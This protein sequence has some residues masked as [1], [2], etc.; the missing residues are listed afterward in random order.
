MTRPVALGV[1]VGGTKTRAALVDPSG[2]VVASDEAPTGGVPQADPGLR[3]SLAVARAVADQAASFGCRVEC[4]GVGVP[5]FVEPDGT[6]HSALVI[7]WEEQP[8]DL[9]AVLGPTI[10]ES[11]VRCGA[12]AES[13]LGAGRQRT[14]MLYVSVGTGISATLVIDGR[15][16]AGARGEAISLGELPVDRV[17]DVAS[18]A[19]LEEFASG[20][21]MGRRL[22]VAGA[23]D[24]MARAAQGDADAAAVVRSSA[25]ALGSALA[26]AVS[27]VDPQVVVLGGGLGTSGGAW[28]DGVLERYRALGTPGIPPVVPAE[29]GPD[30]GVIG[31][32]LVAWGRHGTAGDGAC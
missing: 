19:T 9:F 7:A 5:E 21:A 15:P 12:I 26:W 23:R 25:V 18:T 1:D 20:G 4:V 17:A 2:A 16:W 8:R 24:A 29:L 14:S 22:G 30:S 31:A 32:G 13:V 11:D 27:L 28:F 10:V 3:G 6:L